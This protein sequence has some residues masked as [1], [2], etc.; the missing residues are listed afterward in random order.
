MFR[1]NWRCDISLP[2]DTQLISGNMK[3]RLATPAALIDI[4]DCRRSRSL[5]P[6]RKQ[7]RHRCGNAARRGRVIARGQEAAIPCA[8]CSSAGLIGD[9]ARAAQGSSAARSPTTIRAADYPRPCWRSA[10][11]VNDHA[12]HNRS[13][14]FSRGMFE[15]ALSKGEIRQPK[16]AFPVPRRAG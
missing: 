4:C 11:T 14:N 7:A 15:T 8:R 10:A 9:P 12:A 1:D 6:R 16:S 2:A 3:Q 5:R 13:D